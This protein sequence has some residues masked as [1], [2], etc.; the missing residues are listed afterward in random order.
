[1]FEGFANVWTPVIFSRSLGK[2][3]LPVMLAG[4]QL[5]FFRDAAGQA[6]ALVDR[7]PHR[8]V[9]LSLGR[10]SEEGCLVC[11]FHEWAFDGKG[12]VQRVPLNPDAKRERL[13]AKSVP[14]REVGGVIFAYTAPVTEAPCEPTVPEALTMPGL[15]RTYL[16]VEWAAHWTRAME[17]MLDSPHVPFVHATTIG[18]FVRPHLKPDSRMNIS[19][20]DKPYGG[21]TVATVDDRV[22]DGASLDFFRP[23][24]MVLTIPVPK[25]VFRM[26]SFCVPIDGTRVRMLI[27][28][29]RS[30]AKL[31]LLNPFF[32]RSNAKIAQQDKAVV[33]SS[34][35]VVVPPPGD[36]QSVR[37]DRATLQFRKYFYETLHASRA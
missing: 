27:V 8:G 23:N 10:V 18:R 37:T 26:H 4:E 32:N 28:G 30:F 6:Q 9:A 12:R 1:M 25:Q 5:V 20:E 2:K 7:C 31:P 24:M 3:P 14:V 15:A 19:W 13:F 33:E 16:E 17:N 11:P 36:E 22:A 35:P 29:A 34:Q 21:R